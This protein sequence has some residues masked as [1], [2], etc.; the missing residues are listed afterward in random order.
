LTTRGP[1]SRTAL[2]CVVGLCF[3]AGCGAE[4]APT[5]VE[6][7]ATATPP[8]PAA[9]P[10]IVGDSAIA[11]EK[12]GSPGRALLQWWRAIQFQDIRAVDEL[13]DSSTAEQFGARRLTRLARKVG[14]GLGG[15]RILGADLRGDEATIRALVLTFE[16]GDRKADSTLPLSFILRRENGQWRYADRNYL[17]ALAKGYGLDS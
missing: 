2:G 6:K 8:A 1:F 16:P 11:A 15:V 5:P 12:P 17:E 3:L 9:A 7:T 13:T 4:D 14:S 10:N